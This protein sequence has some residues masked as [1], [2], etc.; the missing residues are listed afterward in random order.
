[1]FY[2]QLFT[3]KRGSL[4]KI[5][6]AAHWE[7]K[8]TKPHVFECNLEVTVR[9][10]LSP[11]MKVGLRTSGHLLIGLVRIYSRKAKYLLADCTIALGKISTSFRPDQT[12]MCVGRLEA[13]VK[14]IT[15]TEDFTAF[16][17]ELPH[18]CDIDIVLVVTL[19]SPSNTV[20]DRS[21]EAF[22]HHD[23]AFG[24]EDK[25]LDLLD[26]LG[27]SSEP[28]DL[29]E[30]LTQ[31]TP[32]S[33]SPNELQNQ[34][35]DVILEHNVSS[36]PFRNM[37]F[38]LLSSSAA[39]EGDL[40]EAETPTPNQNTPLADME[41]ETPTPHQSTLLADMEVAFALEPVAMTP[42]SEK[43]VGKRK[44]KLLVDQAKDLSNNFIRKQL[45]DFSDLVAAL[46]MAPPTVQLMYWKESG[47]VN[48]LFSQPCSAVLGPQIN[49]LFVK[50]SLN[51]SYSKP[52]GE[53]EEMRQDGEKIQSDRSSLSSD[54]SVRDS[55]INPDNTRTE[56]TPLHDTNHNQEGHSELL[57]DRN[58]S[59]L[60]H[61]DLPSEDSMFVHPSHVEQESQSTSLLSQSMLSSQDFEEKRITKRAQKLLHALKQS[62][63][64][65]DPTFSLRSLC[66]GSTRAQAAAIFFSF[67]VLRKQHAL[68]LH[69]SAPYKDVLATPGPT[70][71]SL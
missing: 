27:M 5:W 8:L 44:R 42:N 46:D 1:M 34:S 65:S 24:D 11:K 26:F 2:T 37:T 12:D 16:D 6:L 28:T 67:L 68:H 45:S 60:T 48:K 43:R 59:E 40:M 39:P 55:W 21:F 69:Q 4:A 33:P 10:I 71:H 36:C 47:S 19:W 13:R 25:G 53:V 35:G 56:L 30:E 7:R 38:V 66:E 62:Q 70:Y 20:L 18:P 15:L 14:E 9:E 17:V 64:G 57:H 22:A 3:S 49:Q 50:N 63:S 51:Q 41:A 29:M 58:L 52:R 31:Q 32:E 54:N 23:D 61:L